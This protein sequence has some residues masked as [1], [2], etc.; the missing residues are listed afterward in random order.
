KLNTIDV[1]LFMF[2]YRTSKMRQ[3]KLS[4]IIHNS[5][6]YPD[7]DE[8]SIEVHFLEIIDLS[9][10]NAYSVVPN[11]SLV[12]AHTVTKSNNS[13]YTLN[14]LSSTYTEVQTLLSSLALMFALHVFKV[15]PIS[16][17]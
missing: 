4:E 7:L 3:G 8:C 13:W 5:A 6:Q 17:P 10:L 15:N 11:S 16:T 12:V 14:S 1:L 2:G 9:G